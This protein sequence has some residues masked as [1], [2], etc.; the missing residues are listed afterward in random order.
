MSIPFVD[1]KSQ[2]HEL[3]SEI[4][5]GIDRVLTHGRYV[6]GPEIDELESALAAFVGVRNVV[7]CSSGTDALLI[8]LMA[9]DLQ[10]GD[11]VF[12][13]PFTFMATAEVVTILGATPVFVDIDPDTYNLDPA[14][15]AEA[16]QRILDQGE[17]RPRA[18]IPVDLFGVP[19]DYEAIE[20]VA[21]DSGLLV[22]EDAGQAFG[23]LYRGQR[24][25]SFGDCAATSF[26]PSKPLGCYGD[27]GAIMTDDDD[28]AALLRSVRVHGQGTDKYDNVRIGINGRLDSLQAAVLLAKLPVLERELAARQRVAER[29]SSALAQAV[30]IPQIPDGCVSAW[31]QYS[32]L[33]NTRDAAVAALAK[34][35][36]PTAIHYPKPLHLQQAYAGLGYDAGSLPTAER[37]A[38]RIFSLPIH[39]YLE[40]HAQAAVIDAVLACH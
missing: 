1:L 5:A 19:A 4:R 6:S 39:P 11:A 30:V 28:L 40:E 35:G 3:E 22:L 25:G 14:L 31:A 10:P 20:A 12:T 9:W 38:D 7:G 2:F 8:P 17:L 23:A 16:I 29:Y 24:A 32:V 33:S 18:V 27:G 13:T 15:L 21:E 34:A 36:V 26:F 37:T